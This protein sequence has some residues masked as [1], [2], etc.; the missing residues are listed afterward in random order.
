[1]NTYGV[2][3]LADMAQLVAEHSSRSQEK[4]KQYYD[5]RAKIRSFKMGD[6]LLVLLPTAT[7]RLKLQWTGPCKVTKKLGN[8]DY[9]VETPG[10]R[11]ERKVYHVNLMKK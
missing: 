10:R 3:I 9:E 11:Q 8:V 1:V 2:E 6:Q 4:Q 7:N 5:T